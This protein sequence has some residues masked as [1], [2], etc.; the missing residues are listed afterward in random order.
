MKVQ[1]GILSG[2]QWRMLYG[3]RRHVCMWDALTLVTTS[4]Q[5]YSYR[6][7]VIAVAVPETVLGFVGVGSE[8]LDGMAFK[9][10]LVL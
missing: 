7:E 1:C 2:Q 5:R 9:L 8:Y 6:G 4:F 3:R 10:V